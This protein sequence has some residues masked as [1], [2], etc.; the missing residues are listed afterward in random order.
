MCSINR[1]RDNV[2]TLFH[3]GDTGDNSVAPSN[4]VQ[5]AME[6]GMMIAEATWL[7]A[8]STAP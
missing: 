6:H 3:D 4:D 8:L 1:S 5:I 7:S 2:V